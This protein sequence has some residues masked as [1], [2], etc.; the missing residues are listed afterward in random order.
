MVAY[1]PPGTNSV[2]QLVTFQACTAVFGTTHSNRLAEIHMLFCPEYQSRG[3]GEG[4]LLI[5][6]TM[7][8]SKSDL[9]SMP[10]QEQLRSSS[11]GKE[12]E[13]VRKGRKMTDFKLLE[14]IS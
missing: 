6:P 5:T 12:G 3:K 1:P 4:S 13:Q 11:V 10:L 7:G 2:A 14:T 9:E 8:S